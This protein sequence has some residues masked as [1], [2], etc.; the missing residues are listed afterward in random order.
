M[1]ELFDILDENGNYTK[2]QEERRVAHST[3]LWHR[4]VVVFIVNSKNEV[5]LQRRSPLKRKWANLLDVSA[6]GHTNAGEFGYETAIRETFE[7]LGFKIKKQDL[8]FIGCTKNAFKSGDIVDNMFNEYY[9]V[10]AEVDLSTL[11][12]Q[13]EEVS[14]IKFVTLTELKNMMSSGYRELTPKVEAYEFLLKYMQKNN[15]IN[16]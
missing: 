6:G 13:K 10:N 1:S 12:L 4:A 14:E 9:I 3:G 11:N 5:L 15:H 16:I 8:T 7:E 2:T